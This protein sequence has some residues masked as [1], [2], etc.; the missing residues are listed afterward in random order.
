M[1]TISIRIVKSPQIRFG[2]SQSIFDSTKRLIDTGTNAQGMRFAIVPKTSSFDQ[3]I[4]AHSGV[5]C[6]FF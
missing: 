4:S 6:K 3:I 5:E 2:S 1:Y